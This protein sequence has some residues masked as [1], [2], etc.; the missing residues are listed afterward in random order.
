MTFL[1]NEPHLGTILVVSNDEEYSNSLIRDLHDIGVN[2]VGPTSGSNVALALAAQTSPNL[3]IVADA[4]TDDRDAEAL[5]RELHE[6]WGVRSVVL[7]DATPEGLPVG[8]QPWLVD[9][10]AFDHLRGLLERAARAKR[11][12]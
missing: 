11:N 5:A 2:V 9:P 10:E 1:M 7:D 12:N 6:T 8:E 4:P 3:A